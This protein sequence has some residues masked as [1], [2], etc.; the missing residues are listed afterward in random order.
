MKL[1]HSPFHFIRAFFRSFFFGFSLSY[2][3]QWPFQSL[4][5]SHQNMVHIACGFYDGKFIFF[6][7]FGRIL[8]S[9]VYLCMLYSLFRHVYAF[10]FGF[11]RFDNGDTL[12]AI[13]FS[14]DRVVFFDDFLTT[15]LKIE[16]DM[17]DRYLNWINVFNIHIKNHLFGKLYRM[18]KSVNSDSTQTI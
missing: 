15:K 6:H 16:C 2:K 13:P 3:Q 10:P 18:K 9:R 5:L 12:S 8:S 11:L 7:N 14:N 17:I 4:S 1:T